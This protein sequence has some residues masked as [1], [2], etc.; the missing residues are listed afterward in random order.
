M[1]PYHF[2]RLLQHLMIAL[3]MLCGPVSLHACLD[4]DFDDDLFQPNDLFRSQTAYPGAAYH[5]E[6]E[7]GGFEETFEN[8]K[9][10]CERDGRRRDCTRHGV[11]LALKGDLDGALAQLMVVE[12]DFPG[13]YATAVS[14]ATV[15]ALKRQFAE[16]VKWMEKAL[17]IEPRGHNGAESIHLNIL[18]IELAGEQAT[19]TS[20]ELIGYD[21]GTDSIPRSRASM[22]ALDTL[23]GN[24]F[25]ILDQREFFRKGKK[26]LIAARLAFELGN[27]NFIRGFPSASLQNYELAKELGFKDPL[28]ETRMASVLTSDYKP[29][30]RAKDI[31]SM[32][33]IMRQLAQPEEKAE[34]RNKYIA[35]LFFVM[36]FFLLAVVVVAGVVLY[37]YFERR[38]H[39][40]PIKRDRFDDLF[41][42]DD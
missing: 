18:R 1:R 13:M 26:D 27:L 42:D 25:L 15:H 36:A 12:A 2:R 35:S 14:I 28:L 17:A 34:R 11:C 20:Q 23:Q 24:L 37:R 16:A 8:W 19:C 6:V 7:G 5:A 39:P 10:R 3:A 4:I 32:E 31:K 21:F 33:K 38:S 9:K 41:R 22:E 29:P 30:V 40:A